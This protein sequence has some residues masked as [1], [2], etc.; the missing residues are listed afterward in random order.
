MD[1]GYELIAGERRTL[2][3]RKAGFELVPAIIYSVSNQ[4]SLQFALIENVQ[5]DDLNAIELGKAYKMLMD[6]FSM[7]QDQVAEKVGK[8]RASVSNYVRLLT[9]N[10]KIQQMILDGRL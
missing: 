6:E 5:R 10:L 8:D 7:T 2:A 9:L 3:A 1:S 4:E